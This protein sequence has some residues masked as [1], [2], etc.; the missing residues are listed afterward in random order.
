MC[1]ALGRTSV[2]ARTQCWSRGDPPEDL[3]AEAERIAVVH[4]MESE[5]FI[6]S[7]RSIYTTTRLRILWD[8]T[9]TAGRGWEPTF[10]SGEITV[11]DHG[12][13]VT[14]L[15]SSGQE[16]FQIDNNPNKAVIVENGIDIVY[17]H[18][19][20]PVSPGQGF[21]SFVGE[22]NVLDGKRGHTSFTD[23]EV[24]D[25]TARPIL[26]EQWHALIQYSAA[27]LSLLGIAP[28]QAEELAVGELRG[29][30]PPDGT[31]AH[32]ASWGYVKAQQVGR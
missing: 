14:Y 4:G 3:V 6:D 29:L 24:V 28:S 25:G 16:R 26:L 19:L 13:M 23:L 20:P 17:L 15:D 9:Q 27:V 22:W 2:P 18:R 8:L 30:R 12:G 21:S 5:T 32:S 10:R 11:V 31:A 1:F 7:D